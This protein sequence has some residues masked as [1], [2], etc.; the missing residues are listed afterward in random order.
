MSFLTIKEKL[1]SKLQAISQIQQVHDY[2][3]E[4]FNGYPSAMVRT[5][6]NT[7]QFETSSENQELY[8]F[9]IFLI[10]NLDGIHSVVK[11][12]EIIEELCDTVRDNID[13]DEFLSGISLPSGRVMI[14]ATP[15]VSK[16]Y[17]ANDGK[18]VV[19]EVEVAVRVS[20]VV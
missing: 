7:S 14:G 13:S 5:D 2:P 17:E 8:T 11:A 20:K 19:A 15:T 12:R 3:T 9:T 1:K 10:Q 6:G 4:D 16:I 18:Y